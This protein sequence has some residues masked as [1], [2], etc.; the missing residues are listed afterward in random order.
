MIM[1]AKSGY[2]P[3][4][5]GYCAQSSISTAPIEKY[6]FISKEEILDIIENGKGGMPAGILKGEDAEAVASWLADKK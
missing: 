1:N 3:E 5:C 2:C 6:P 4:N